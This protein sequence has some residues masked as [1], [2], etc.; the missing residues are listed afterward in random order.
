[1]K[2]NTVKSSPEILRGSLDSISPE[3]LR[4]ACDICGIECH[5]CG[6]DEV[7]E[8]NEIDPDTLQTLD[9]IYWCLGCN[10][11]FSFMLGTKLNELNGQ[12]EFPSDVEPEE[13]EYYLH[14]IGQWGTNGIDDA[15]LDGFQDFD[16]ITPLA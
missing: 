6:S 5:E 4:Q 12:A 13:N 7:Y 15:G 16:G 14:Q 8:L 1:V 11:K 9:V 10:S 3:I 2:N